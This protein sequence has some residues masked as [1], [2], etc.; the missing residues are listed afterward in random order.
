MEDHDIEVF[1]VLEESLLTAEGRRSPDRLMA[2]I[3][4]DFVEFGSSGRIFGRQDVID[5]AGALPDIS[6]PLQDFTATS[7]SLT[8]VLVTYRSTTRRLNG[9]TQDALRSSVWTMS[10]RGWRLLFHQGTLIPA[11]E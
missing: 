8:A 2:L 1:R 11:T 7:L 9:E 6:T 3:A 10:N 5:A 4:E